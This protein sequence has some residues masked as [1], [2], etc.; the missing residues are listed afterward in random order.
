L[1]TNI[2]ISALDETGF[3][4]DNDT[5]SPKSYQTPERSS[6]PKKRQNGS[7][8]YKTSR[9][10]APRN[11]RCSDA[12]KFKQY[13]DSQRELRQQGLYRQAS[14]EQ[15]IYFGQLDE[16]N[17]AAHQHAAQQ[18]LRK[19]AII[20][21][22]SQE[23]LENVSRELRRRSAL[24]AM[25]HVPRAHM[26]RTPQYGGVN[27]VLGA[28]RTSQWLEACIKTCTLSESQAAR[29]VAKSSQQ[30]GHSEHEIVAPKSQR[31]ST[32]SAR[33]NNSAQAAKSKPVRQP[34]AS[35]KPAKSSTM[36]RQV[37]RQVPEAA[38]DSDMGERTGQANSGLS[39]PPSASPSAPPGKVTTA[40]KIAQTSADNEKKKTSANPGVK[41]QDWSVDPQ[42]LAFEEKRDKEA[43]SSGRDMRYIID[44][45]ANASACCLVNC[46]R[47]LGTKTWHFH[48]GEPRPVVHDDKGNARA[49]PRAP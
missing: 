6:V 13:E 41:R 34:T 37:S 31:A 46:R 39:A 25:G 43:A 48:Q 11:R 17:L 10:S 36:A 42:A 35:S 12:T 45:N 16:A 28:K 1:E 26:E 29:A 20:M 3:A 27:R 44:P 21:G 47:Q 33:V 30:G 40:K 5:M 18:M 15:V 8:D 38:A 14:H 9:V 7:V 23:T 32:D 4:N 49:E 24:A 2:A 19:A 22:R